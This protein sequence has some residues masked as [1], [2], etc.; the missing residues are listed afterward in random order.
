MAERRCESVG[1]VCP[2]EHEITHAYEKLIVGNGELPIVERV[3]NLEAEMATALPIL[4]SLESAANR[5]EGRDIERLANEKKRDKRTQQFR[6]W[7]TTILAILAVVSALYVGLKGIND[8]H[9]GV[10]KIPK[11]GVS[12]QSDNQYTATMNAPVLARK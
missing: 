6:F 2:Y 12:S 3:R 4:Q 5:Q 7:I 9:K 10:L 1:S 11:I 8:L